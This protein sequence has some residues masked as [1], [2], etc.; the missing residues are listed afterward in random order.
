MSKNTKAI[1]AEIDQKIGVK[2]FYSTR[3]LVTAGIFGS[4]ISAR[5]ALQSGRLTYL[6]ISPRRFVVLRPVLLDFLQRNVAVKQE[7]N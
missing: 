4:L 3:E 2:A 7:Q 1:L 5:R 6:I